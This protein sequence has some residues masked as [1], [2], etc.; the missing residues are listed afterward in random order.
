MAGHDG[1]AVVEVEGEV[2][3]DPHRSEGTDLPAHRQTEQIGEKC[4]GGVPV[5][6]RHDRV[7]QDY[8][9]GY[10]REVCDM[11]TIIHAIRMRLIVAS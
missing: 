2:V 4:C 3:V 10:L 1:R 9:H 11:H 6:G 5:G 8:A 7:I